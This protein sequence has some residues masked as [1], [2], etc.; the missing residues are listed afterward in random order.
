MYAALGWSLVAAGGT[1]ATTQAPNA[2]LTGKYA[3]NR[4]LSENAEAKL[5]HSEPG[6]AGHRPPAGMHG[7]GALFGGGGKRDA[8]QARDL[9]LRRPTSLAV[10]QDGT[11]IELTDSAGRVRVLRAS[12]QQERIDGH[13]VRTNWHNGR[14]VSGTSLASAKLTDTYERM[15]TPPQVIVTT[16][17]E[18]RGSAVTVRRV[19]D[20]ESK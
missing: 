16:R 17:M 15:H 4:E 2:D 13:E 6:A 10:I 3:L 18:M 8:E 11:R 19:Y 5:Q 9:F 14:L 20:A 1:V 7:L 12:G